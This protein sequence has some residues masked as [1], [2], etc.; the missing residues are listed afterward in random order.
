M[1]DP[2]LYRKSLNFRARNG[3][4]VLSSYPK[5][6]THW[7]AYIMQLILKRGQ[8]IKTYREFTENTRLLEMIE[9][10]GWKPSLPMRIVVTRPAPR[11]ELV[12]NEAKYVYVA[13]NPWDVCVS[14]YHM[15]TNISNYRF[16]DATFEEF[17]DVFLAG[18]LGHGHFFDH[19]SA[20]Y[21]LRDEPNVFFVTYEELAIDTRGTV[22]RLAR[23][24]GQGYATELEGDE[25]M[26]EKLLQRCKADYMRDVIVA[27]F[28][29]RSDGD[30]ERTL[31]RLNA[32]CKD[33][34]GGDGKKFAFVRKGV[35]G[36]WKAYFTPKLLLRM[37][38]AIREAENKSSVTK[39]WKNMRDEALMALHEN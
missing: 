21:A 36:D 35:V 26:L 16:T 14:T 29:D 18:D 19:V 5:T 33:G 20:G 8:P 27:S 32:D 37:E 12:N 6:G 1:Y 9:L 39:L 28:D 15:F 22:L 30:W 31:V 4:L 25:A 38:A 2:Q 13:R 11:K 23:F 3:D 10:E 24:L 34:H 7:V 17:V